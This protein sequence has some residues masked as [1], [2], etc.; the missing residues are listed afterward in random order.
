MIGQDDKIVISRRKLESIIENAIK[1]RERTRWE[2]TRFSTPTANI[3][4]AV[5]LEI[6]TEMALNDNCDITLEVE[7][8]PS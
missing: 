2:V 7:N 8:E 4:E 5:F 6:E 3:P 1:E